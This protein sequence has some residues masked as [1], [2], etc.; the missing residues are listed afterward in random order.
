MHHRAASTLLVFL[1]GGALPPAA[2]ACGE[3]MFSTG[4][5]LPYEAY[6]APR[7]AAVLVYV[8][9]GESDRSAQ[10]ALHAGLRKAGHGVTVVHDADALRQAVLGSRYDVVISAIDGVDAVAALEADAPPALLPV[11]ARSMRNAPQVRNR[12]DLFLLEGASLGQYLRA[13]N[14]LVSP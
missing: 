8:E 3:G 11:V 13:I 14:T 10:Q 4:K 12:F 1:L 2:L 5:G 7:P 6:R 9:G